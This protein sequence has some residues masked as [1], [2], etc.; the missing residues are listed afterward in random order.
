MELDTVYLN[1]YRVEETLHAADDSR[2][3]VAVDRLGGGDRVI[4]KS[5]NGRLRQGGRA[6]RL[7]S[8]YKLLSRLKHPGL[9]RG[10]DFGEDLRLRRT[11]LVM[12]RAPGVP[13]DQVAP[14]NADLLLMVMAQISRV[15]SYLHGR[16]ILHLDVKPHN[17][18]LDKERGRVTLLDLDLA[19]ADDEEVR[20]G[21][22]PY[23]AP[24][25][26]IPGQKASQR[27]D[28]Y[29][30]GITLGEVGRGVCLL[31]GASPSGFPSWLAGPPG[32]IRRLI[33]KLHAQEP[34]DRPA[35]A[36]DVLVELGSVIP[37]ALEERDTRC[38]S[39]GF[40]PRVGPEGELDSLVDSLVGTSAGCKPVLVIDGPSGLGRSRLLEDLSVLCRLRGY[41]VL[42]VRPKSGALETLGPVREMF[43]RLSSM[44]GRSSSDLDELFAAPAATRLGH[45]E[46]MV[47]ATVDLARRGRVLLAL[48][49]VHLMDR[50][51][52]DY[53]LHLLRHLAHGG[54]AT[55]VAAPMRVALSADLSSLRDDN[56]RS[57]IQSEA[58]NH[59]MHVHA[60]SPF[61]YEGSC[62][63]VRGLVSPEKPTE[64]LL[65]SLFEKSGGNP[66]AIREAF[67]THPCHPDGSGTL[68][69]ALRDLSPDELS[70]PESWEEA[71]LS[72]L[73]HLSEGERLLL[74]VMACFP[75]GVER[76]LLQHLWQR[77]D[78]EPLLLTLASSDL[79]EF[80]S[81]RWFVAERL[82][83]QVLAN[84]IEPE[85]SRKLHSLAA[86]WL[87]RTGESAPRVS[88][89]L[90]HGE[91]PRAGLDQAYHAVP[92]LLS[93]H[94]EA[95]AVALLKK[96][97]S[98]PAISPF[99][100]RWA[101]LMRFDLALDRGQ[102]ATA[103]RLIQA[104]LESR[105]NSPED[106]ALIMRK[107]RIQ[108]REGNY[109]A[110]ERVLGVLLRYP[111]SL[112]AED[113]AEV[114]LE[115]ADLHVSQ[116][117]M[118]E[119]NRALIEAR[120]LLRLEG[121]LESLEFSQ[122][123][124][125]DD[126]CLSE[127]LTVGSPRREALVGRFLVLLATVARLEQDCERGLC[128]LHA[129]VQLR[130]RSGDRMGLAQ[131]FHGIGTLHAAQGDH[132]PA[133]RYY[134][135][136]LS[137]RTKLGDLAGIGD[138]AN[139]LGV[140]LRKLG[141]TREALDRFQLSLKHRRQIGHVAGECY[142]H[143]NIANVHYERR[144]L[145]AALRYYHRA[146]T[147]AKRLGDRGSQALILNNLGAV[148][149]LRGTF[150]V[151]IENYHEAE[152]LDRLRGR[153][154]I[155]VGRRI[156]R[157]ESHLGLGDVKSA[158]SLLKSVRRLIRAGQ[159]R[160]LE[161]PLL[162]AE[163]RCARLLGERRSR[164]LTTLELAQKAP[165]SH[166][167]QDVDL[168]Y[169][170][171]LLGEDP[172]ATLRVLDGLDSSSSPESRLQI[173][174]LRSRALVARG[175]SEFDEIITELGAG[176]RAAR[177]AQM[178]I[179]EFQ[180]AR[181]R[182]SVRSHTGDHDLAAAAHGAALEAIERILTGIHRPR[183]RDLFMGTPDV[184]EWL[185]DVQ[186][187]ASTVRPAEQRKVTSAAGRALM[188]VRDSLFAI[189]RKLASTRR[190]PG[191][192]E[193]AMR[194]LIS[195]SQSLKTT[196]PLDQLLTQIVD[197]VVE[198]SRAERGFLI[199]VD[200]RGTIRIPVARTRDLEPVQG[201]MAQV[202]TKIIG[203]ALNSG[204][205][206]RLTD[207]GDSGYAHTESV[208]N[209]DLR[210]VV[211][212]PLRHQGA[213]IGFLY[214]DNRSRV[215]QFTSQDQELIDLFATQAAVTLEN[216][217]MVRERSRDE[218]LRVM[219]R[220]SGDVA[221]DFNH[222]LTSILWR[223]ETVS[224]K[225]V[226]EDVKSVL[227][228][229]KAA[230]MEGVNVVSR[231]QDLSRSH[232]DGQLEQLPL[233]PL[234]EDSLEYVRPQLEASG[235]PIEVVLDV[236]PDLEV[237]GKS[238][239]LKE[240]FTNLFAN[241]ALAM[242]AGGE[243]TVQG[244]MMGDRVLVSVIDTG[245]GMTQ[246]VQESV[247]DP[248]FTTR[249][250]D[251]SGLG[252]SIVRSIIDRH[253]GEIRVESSVGEG[254]QVTFDLPPSGSE[255]PDGDPGSSSNG[256]TPSKECLRGK[257]ILVVDDESSI[258]DLVHAALTPLGVHVDLAPG[259]HEGLRLLRGERYDCV[260][261][262]LGMTPCNGWEVARG[263]KDADPATPVV[264]MT[265]RGAEIDG[266]Q[267]RNRGVDFLVSKPFSL[268]RLQEIL[269][270][271]LAAESTLGG[272][273]SQSA[274]H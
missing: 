51:S 220:L 37:A 195:L 98:R 207:A 132:E 174:I 62:A 273:D 93:R 210:S 86:A 83:R 206:V 23:V 258:R 237:Y 198:F 229:V 89:H 269:A 226:S 9:P 156:N 158:V 59:Q 270:S 191:R 225:P 108:Q 264:L 122:K 139:N 133:E 96:I 121:F 65:R 192:G 239:E 92:D 12:S 27:S 137:L 87:E 176:E 173:L 209:L 53:V 201:P 168:A 52:R 17:I 131:A 177:R 185:S 128:A 99:A 266:A 205:S 251:G 172:E 8:E 170:E 203:D 127:T 46:R 34:A 202:S 47:S 97:G 217:R 68:M 85:D 142:S 253:G 189:D 152:R 1:R 72:Q 184:R 94:G 19:T 155:A 236:S 48:D 44:R 263:A 91:D 81:G 235:S 38:A 190:A 212:A 101:N 181:T 260:L 104:E 197:G 153:T 250:E 224:D 11:V 5:C 118:S 71:V 240:A 80:A 105:D 231:L 134:K 107:A 159:D 114:Q 169:A 262:D 194:R 268:T 63:F 57:W 79:L 182:A 272:M 187:L 271:F 41:R 73:A 61:D 70:L 32:P 183:H 100:C 106:A 244:R 129:V 2:V 113:L 147:V 35:T 166:N 150:E 179:L 163:A 178:S 243:L 30:L 157:A 214:V 76:S 103:R 180:C 254:T 146:L 232:T 193:A 175:E 218:K 33:G 256:S 88:W 148:A 161:Q 160:S 233:R 20:R 154:R 43:E 58:G 140:L 261:T 49:D 221:H 151:A 255:V 162:L 111:R 55:H 248:Y 216:A 143:I 120:T 274:H 102:L 13:L 164:V 242:P 230:A 84:Q 14:L 117:S 26:L 188:G 66:L 78:M 40:P 126:Q 227:S 265:G 171:A 135:R 149:A 238:T 167:R 196:S 42:P 39:L 74:K 3:E 15:L 259:G 112:S 28:L 22:V 25:V 219:G 54:E 252:M 223:L 234:V 69:G 208:M 200:S 95:E 77:G 249:G 7:A 16:G 215:G 241:S 186:D 199:T 222:L 204:R 24:E 110:C 130:T 4:L 10:V 136:A 115:L 125:D 90:L 56:L 119:A 213:I 36:R 116:G 50:A 267:A 21:T 29:S 60:L 257:R 141:R 82:D 247:F 165:E 246:E 6:A 145:E 211:C 138:T 45:L 31:P 75:E 124:G 64:E 144:E 109:Q 18:L 228:H 123:G 245:Q 67:L